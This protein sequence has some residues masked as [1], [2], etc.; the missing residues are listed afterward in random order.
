MS[1]LRLQTLYELA[2]LPQEKQEEYAE[3]I[4]EQ[5]DEDAIHLQR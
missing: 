5:F 2:A 4:Q 1:D 3:L